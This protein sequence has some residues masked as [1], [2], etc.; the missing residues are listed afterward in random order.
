MNRKHKIL[1]KFPDILCYNVSGGMG[2][3]QNCQEEHYEK[4]EKRYESNIYRDCC[5]AYRAAFHIHL[6]SNPIK[7]RGEITAAIRAVG[8]S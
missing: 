4:K 1:L 3:Q 7:K 6:S 2:M 8:R 5:S